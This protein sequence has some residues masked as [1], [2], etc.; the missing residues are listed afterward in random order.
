MLRLRRLVQP[1]GP[2]STA[3]F[4]KSILDNEIRS[5]PKLAVLTGMLWASSSLMPGPVDIKL[6]K[7]LGYWDFS[8]C[9]FGMLF[10]LL[11]GGHAHGRT[12]F[13]NVYHLVIVPPFF[14]GTPGD[15]QFSWR[16]S[17][18]PSRLAPIYATTLGLKPARHKPQKSKHVCHIENARHGTQ[19]ATTRHTNLF[20]LNNKECSQGARAC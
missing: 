3:T 1:Y 17:P 4:R 2:A 20:V 14:G 11:Q 6:P 18:A 8:L 9:A 5:C 7:L 13:D 16:C 12:T 19:P 10:V 15:W